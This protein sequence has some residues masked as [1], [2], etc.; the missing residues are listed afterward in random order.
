MTEDYSEHDTEE[1]QSMSEQEKESEILQYTSYTG[2]FSF[3]FKHKLL[4]Y[5]YFIFNIIFHKP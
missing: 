5:N 4:K 3:M 2:E 1:Y